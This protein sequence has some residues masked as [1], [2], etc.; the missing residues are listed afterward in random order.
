MT[1][2]RRSALGQ[3]LL[4]QRVTDLIHVVRAFGPS[5]IKVAA[6]RRLTVPALLAAA[7]E[8][9]I[10]E[11]TLIEGLASFRHVIEAEQYTVPFANFA[12]GLL[13]HTDLPEIAAR[14][15]RRLAI[16][17]P[18]DAMGKP[19]APAEVAKLYPQAR[20]ISAGWDAASLSAI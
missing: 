20:V 6:W 11:V 5:K 2:G 13:R 17:K 3:S 19:L 1:H 9:R 7:L 18:V 12:P 8:P 10:A 14:I 4:A 15:G 16:S